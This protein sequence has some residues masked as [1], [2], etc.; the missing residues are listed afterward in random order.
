M[1]WDDRGDYGNFLRVVRED[2]QRPPGGGIW[3]QG[4]PHV[5][6]L[7]GIPRIWHRDWP[8]VDAWYIFIDSELIAGCTHK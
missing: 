2:P 6:Q 4:A 8:R 7:S 5:F 3:G 1:L